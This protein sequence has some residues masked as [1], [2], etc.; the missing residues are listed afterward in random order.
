MK[1]LLVLVL[2]ATLF[3]LSA[4]AGGDRQKTACGAECVEKL[5]TKYA[6]KAWLGVEYAKMD[7]GYYKIA[8]KGSRSVFKFFKEVA[9]A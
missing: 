4:M 5:K 7:N 9:R 8:V 1:K 2:A 3:P 6:N